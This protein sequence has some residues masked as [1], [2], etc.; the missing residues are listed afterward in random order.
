MRSATAWALVML[1][2]ALS[3]APFVSPWPVAA[4]QA[5]AALAVMRRRRLFVGFIA[6]TAAW[7]VG[8]L[9]ALAT[10]P[11]IT[12]GPVGFAAAGA[13]DGL[14]ATARLAAVL[15]VNLAA[16]DHVRAAAWI[17]A[18]RLPRRATALLAAVLLAARDLGRDHRSLMD[19]YSGHDSG[20]SRLARRLARLRAAVAIM[21]SLVVLAV[22]R[23]ET[24][25]EALQ[26]AGVQVAPWFGPVAAMTALA[27][28]GRLAL[29]A[30]PNV[31]LVYVTVF[32]AGVL[33]GARVGA[34]VGALSMLL[35]DLVLTGL[36]P[37][38][39]VNVPA[40]A[41]V[42][43]LGGL[44]R[45]WR[46]PAWRAWAAA[47][48]I[49]ATLAF[50]VAADSIEWLLVPELRAEPG[51]WQLRVL[52]GL[53][54]NALPALTNAFLFAAAVGPVAAALDAYDARASATG[55][56]GGPARNANTASGQ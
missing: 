40:M 15:G 19:L 31:S 11:G 37:G 43:A 1:V 42:G 21:P 27:V 41:L 25:R 46:S 7:N 54:F 5:V 51:A 36:A 45:D 50:S 48:G 49:V 10:G 52:A 53:L 33:F 35:T 32:L 8:V 47:A 9:A 24:R 3:V 4:V 17:D 38:A 6:F 56:A 18:L 44:W 39:F 2:G 23:G 55:A 30:I 28:A 26:V 20:G 14:R 22:R 16:L 34:G 29:V 12:I 13:I